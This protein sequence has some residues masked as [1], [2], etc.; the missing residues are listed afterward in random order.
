[1]HYDAKLENMGIPKTFVLD[2][3][4]EGDMVEGVST[5]GVPGKLCD[6]LYCT[7]LVIDQRS[8]EVVHHS[9]SDIRE[10]EVPTTFAFVTVAAEY[11]DPIHRM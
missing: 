3:G 7:K 2:S 11:F 9:G 1:V 4:H 5:L 6:S 10:S 8:R